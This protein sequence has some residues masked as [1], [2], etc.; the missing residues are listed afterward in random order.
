MASNEPHL[1][2]LICAMAEFRR[3]LTTSEALSL[4]NDLI[5]GT[6]TEESIFKWKKVC[7]EY[8]EDITVLER[9]WW[10]LFK[11]RWSHT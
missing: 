4:G 6:P 11:N 2:E 3:C 10:K 1:V 5:C 8:K 9:K 7:N